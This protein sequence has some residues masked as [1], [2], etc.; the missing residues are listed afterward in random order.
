MWEFDAVELVSAAVSVGKY[1]GRA[2]VQVAEC[3]LVDGVSSAAALLEGC[4]TNL[5]CDYFELA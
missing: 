5:L 2:V 3:L 4:K 1:C